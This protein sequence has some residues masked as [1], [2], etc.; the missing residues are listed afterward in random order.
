MTAEIIV[1]NR[2]AVAMAADSL[3]SIRR[4]SSTAST[5]TVKA[6]AGARK[7]VR[8]APNAAVGVMFFDSPDFNGMPWEVIFAEFARQQSGVL[9]HVRDYAD[10]FLEFLADRSVG[11]TGPSDVRGVLEDVLS[12]PV[13]ELSDAWTA[14]T[15]GITDEAARRAALP[16]CV[17]G[18]IDRRRRSVPDAAE[19]VALSKSQ[20]ERSAAQVRALV[21]RAAPAVWGSASR[22]PGVRQKIVEQLLTDLARI[23]PTEPDRAGLAFAGFGERQLLP[24]AHTYTVSGRLAG[25]IRVAGPQSWELGPGRPAVV[26]P[27]AQDYMVQAFM[28]GVHPEI[29]ASLNRM[30]HSLVSLIP[31]VDVEKMVLSLGREFEEQTDRLRQP[32]LDGLAFLSARDVGRLAK[33]L[34]AV[35]AKRNEVA[36]LPDTVGGPFDV[37]LISRTDGFT[38]HTRARRPLRREPRLS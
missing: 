12:G 8:L 3:V 28:A 11:W 2:I 5:A 35:T 34:I 20:I 19:P 15:R 27:L 16:A 38:W 17:D 25:G 36:L 30:M 24:S 18:W 14:A 4:A 21:D 23:S 7:L 1:M 26:L 22:R 10:A 6:Y 33:M 31:G 13:G 9:D 29:Q 32:L 37:A